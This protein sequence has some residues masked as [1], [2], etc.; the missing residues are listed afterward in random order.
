MSE[1]DIELSH[2]RYFV[3]LAEELH[4]GRAAARLHMA[5]PPLTRQI[6]LL[7]ARLQCPLFERNS[8]STRL[9]YAGEQF[10]QRARAILSES[11]STFKMIQG[12]G[13]GEEGHL[14]VA[15]APSLMLTELPR[16][17]R[18]FRKKY[19]MVDFR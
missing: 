8:R 11:D 1:T 15:T 5:Q 18:T 9:T 17:I 19:P 2:L 16:V 4:F 7:E 12:L 6:K 14:T 10:L 13:R 3:V